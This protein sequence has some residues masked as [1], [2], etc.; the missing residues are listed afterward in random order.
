MNDPRVN[1][2]AGKVVRMRRM[3]RRVGCDFRLN[4]N[5]INLANHLDPL[6]G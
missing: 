5:N 3:A 4:W 2:A 1:E 6:F